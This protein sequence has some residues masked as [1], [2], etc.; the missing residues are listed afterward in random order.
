MIAIGLDFG[1]ARIGV[2]V[3]DA[4]GML[5][6]PVETVPAQREAAALDRIAEIVRERNAPCVVLG[7]PVRE[8]GTEGTAAAK[9]RRF[10]GRLA[11]HLP[12]GVRVAFQ[13]EYRST[14]S[15]AEQLRA[16]GRRTP[17]HRRVIDQAAAV[18][19]LQEWLDARAASEPYRDLPLPP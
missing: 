2:A 3:S 17:R 13:D 15:A 18:V 1:S 14:V 6:H 19:I 16:A 12:A 11:A 4:L 10:A 8:D 7:L 5:A 9:V